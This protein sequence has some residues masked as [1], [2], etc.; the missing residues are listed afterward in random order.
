MTKLSIAKLRTIKQADPKD[1]LQKDE[2]QL[3]TNGK[4]LGMEGGI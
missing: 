4:G 3:N 2:H 1:R